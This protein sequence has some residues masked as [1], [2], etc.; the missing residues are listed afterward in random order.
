MLSSIV[1]FSLVCWCVESNILQKF[2]G[3][4][5]KISQF[6]TFTLIDII[7][8]VSIFHGNAPR[9][10]I[11]IFYHLL[12][13]KCVA[14]WNPC[15]WRAWICSSEIILSCMRPANERRRR[16]NVT[17]YLIG[18]SHTQ[19][20]PLFILHSQCHCWWFLSI[21]INHRCSNNGSDRS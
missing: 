9:L 7:P 17:S 20:D 6:H 21:A 8:R 18:W 15:L 1:D 12:T 10:C 14:C 3:Y 2:S 4:L 13:L 19:D 16:Y 5:Y 11:C